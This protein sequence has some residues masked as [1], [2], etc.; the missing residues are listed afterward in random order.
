M[1]PTKDVR[2]IEII[3][4][5]AERGVQRADHAPHVSINK[6]SRSHNK[7]SFNIGDYKSNPPYRQEGM[8]SRYSIF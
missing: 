1:F 4:S 2:T 6:G 3:D 8:K 5:H 7:L